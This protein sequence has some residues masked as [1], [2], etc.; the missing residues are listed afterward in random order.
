MIVVSGSGRIDLFG[1]ILSQG[2][3]SSSVSPI[4][5]IANNSVVVSSSTISSS[6]I[7]FTNT[8]A[9][10]NKFCIAFTNMSSCNTYTTVNNLLLTDEI[11]DINNK[12]TE[13]L[14]LLNHIH[15]QKGSS[16]LS[17]LLKGA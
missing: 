11:N 17:G 14:E 2:S 6:T 10:A 5:N 16:F 3:S 1:C 9:Y 7:Q 4:I 12:I 15:K 13:H 8:T